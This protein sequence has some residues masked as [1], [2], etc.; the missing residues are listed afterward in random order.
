[1]SNKLRITLGILLL[2]AIFLIVRVIS[3]VGGRLKNSDNTTIVRSQ[4][5]ASIG[6]SVDLTD[7]YEDEDADGLSDAQETRFESDTR[8]A[9]TDG[10]GFV[11]GEEAISGYSPIK[12]GDG[13]KL[14][15][16][17]ATKGF[18]DKLIAG[19][20]AGDLNPEKTDSTSI[21]K[22]LSLVALT[23]LAD[24]QKKLSPD[25]SYI[26]K[27]NR[28]GNSLEEKER[29]LQQVAKVFDDVFANYYSTYP[30]LMAKG[31]QA[32]ADDQ[33]DVV[34]SSFHQLAVAS[35]EKYAIA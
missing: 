6:R 27:S 17:N 23:T 20:Y 22:N 3:A 31:M 21:N 12:N 29:Y 18:T 7:L 11:D 25:L 14:I 5:T 33:I 24:A 10:D 26:S 16:D 1:M 13:E 35:N 34:Q 15:P 4:G 30:R 8:K 19:I 9:D 2:V 28:T 32:I